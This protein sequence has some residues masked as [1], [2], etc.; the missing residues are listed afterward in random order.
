MSENPYAAPQSILEGPTA[1]ST[2]PGQGSPYGE[3]RHTTGLAY[4]LI[5]FFG[6]LFVMNLIFISMLW[7]EL[8]TLSDPL[9]DYESAEYL[10]LENIRAPLIAF[11]GILYFMVVILWCVW[12]NKS[13][14]N[15]WLINSRDGALALYRGRKAFTPKWSVVWFFIPIASLWK[16]YQAMAW[17]RDASQKPIGV[18]MGKLVGLWWTFYLLMNFS[19][20]ITSY[21]EKQADTQEAYATFA[22]TSLI[23]SSVDLVSVIFAVLVVFRLTKIQQVRAAELN[24]V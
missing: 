24:L 14:K 8:S 23:L 7:F 3:F 16:P 4:T 22:R 20:R 11:G 21:L 12:M 13:C 1:I 9:Y 2:H 10:A 15:A 17:I 19:S 6:L 5:S 18:N